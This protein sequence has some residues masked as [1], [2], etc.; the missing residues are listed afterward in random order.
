VGENGKPSETED[1]I[2]RVRQGAA[3]AFHEYRKALMPLVGTS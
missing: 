2:S 3:L 1:E